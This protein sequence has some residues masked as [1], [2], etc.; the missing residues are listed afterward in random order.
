MRN[1][2]AYVP[3][4]Q[5]SMVAALARPFYSPIAE[6][7]ASLARPACRWLR[8]PKRSMMVLQ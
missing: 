7:E 4:T 5:Q 3:K 6:H 8:S 1:A 2:L